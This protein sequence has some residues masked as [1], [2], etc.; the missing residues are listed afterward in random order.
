MDTKSTPRNVAVVD[1]ETDPFAPGRMLIRPF[2]A[3]FY[4]GQTLQTWWGA[5]CVEKLVARCKQFDGLIYAHNGGN[6]DFHFL[7]QFLPVEACKFLC[8]GKR[9]VQIKTP[10]RCEFRDSFAIIPK[11]LAS[12]HKTKID[13]RKFEKERREKHRREILAYLADDLRDLRGMV[14]GFLARFPA[15]VTLASATFKL[16]QREFGAETGRATESYDA[17][18]RPYYF[19]GRVQFWRLGRVPG[20][21]STV[22]INSAFPW[23]MT[24]PHAHGFEFRSVRKLPKRNAEQ[25]FY[26]V[27]CDSD[28]ELPL[29]Q[30]DGSVAFPA[31]RHTFHVTGW[32]LLAAVELGAARNLRIETALIPKATRDFARFVNTFY[33]AKVEAKR[34]GDKEEEFFNKI[35]LNGGYGKLALNPR[36]FSEVAVTSIYDTPPE[37][38]GKGKKQREQNAALAGWQVSWDDPERGLTFHKRASYRPGLDQFVN[39]ATAASITGCVRAL[40]MRAK[41]VCKGV[42]YCD[43]DSLTAADVSALKFSDALGDWKL[44][45]TFPGRTAKDSFWIAGKKLYAGYG[46]DADGKWKWKTASKGVRLSPAQIVAVAKGKE[47]THT[48]QAPTYS[49]FSPP[50]FVTRT[51]RRADKR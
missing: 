50:K 26:T 7:L 18:F 49:V 9:I 24:K 35:V 4:D 41:A 11:A 28:G 27:T 17:V 10:W 45:M 43:T 15:E 30:D 8:I 40:L 3:G 21:C 42:V 14:A 6:F 2:C 46:R 32:E 19:A 36:R 44:E 20:R 48:A 47:R 37:I 38:D 51:I 29:R 13:Y 23:A 39:V 25:G 33:R 1:I 16:L 34:R 12:Y 5:D 22:D 31:G